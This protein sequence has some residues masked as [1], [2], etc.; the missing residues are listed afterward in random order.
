M[1]TH[2]VSMKNQ[3]TEILYS[4]LPGE[5]L[6]KEYL[7]NSFQDYV[8]SI[9]IFVALSVIF[10]F[11]Q[12]GILFRLGQLAKKTETSIDDTFIKIV[13]SL[14]PQFYYFLAFYFGVQFLNLSGSVSQAIGAIFTIWIVYQGIVALQILIDD[15]I[16]KK[17]SVD[18]DPG[19]Q[20]AIKYL[21]NIVK[22]ALW[23]IGFL[24]VL[25]NLGVNITSL[26][27]GLGIG[28]LAI[29]FAVQ[30]ILADLFSS[31]AIFFDKPFQ[32]GDFIVAGGSS[33][34]VEK[35]GVKTTRLRALS[36]EEVVIAN[37]E[38]TSARIQNYRN[39]QERRVVL[40]L[41]VL[42]ETSEDKL[43]KIPELI[44]DV[45]TS[46]SKARFDRAHFSGF[47]DSALL[48]EIVYYA[49][50]GDYTEY[51]NIQHE[52]NLGI[53]AIFNQEK[54]GFAYPTQTLYISK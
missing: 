14:K 47:G 9:C 19:T 6:G 37:K 21:S 34:T 54:I 43:A 12:W 25:S 38:L 29:A 33:G 45:V 44:K 22:F 18:K 35:I 11:V 40:S 16:A 48:Y 32:V 13:R 53:V 50:T 39:V 5:F 7:G 49:E 17:F 30:N 51:M 52:V 8:V 10:K 42:Y 24:L 2:C 36:G 1:L 31:F 15:V 41:G 23:A 3:I 4:F 20:S 27:A 46:V 26:V 28:G